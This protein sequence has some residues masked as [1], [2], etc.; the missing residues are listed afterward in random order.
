MKLRLFLA[1]LVLL[2]AAACRPSQSA[3]EVT[4]AVTTV[5]TM[6]PEYNNPL[7]AEQV[8]SEFLDHWQD[9][10]FAGMYALLSFA[11]QQATS[12][13]QFRTAYENAH[14]EMRL[15]SLSHQLL[16]EKRETPRIML[17]N[18]N[19]TFTSRIVGTF[20]DSNRD[21]RL[22]LDDTLQNWRVAWSADDIFRGMGSGGALR[23][24]AFAP[25]RANIYDV[26][27][28]ILADMEGAMIVVNLVLGRVP[29]LDMCVN[30]LSQ[31]TAQTPDDL[32]ARLAN[33]D[34]EQLAEIAVIER[35]VYDQWG[36]ALVNECA[37]TF[38][39]RA[40]RRYLYPELISHV[41]GYVGYPEE[42]EIEALEAA[43]FRQDS[44]IGRTG[45]EA[46]WDATLRGTPGGQ[47]SLVDGSGQRI[48]LLADVG[49]SPAKSVYLTIDIE[50][51]RAAMQ[52]IVDEY[53]TGRLPDSRGAVLIAIDVNTG[54]I[55]ALA[56]YPS[57]NL[58]AFTPYPYVGVQAAA[59][60]I[61][62]TEA[63]SRRPLLNRATQGSYP[64]GSVMK[65]VTAV[66][67][68]EEG[69]F[70]V[71]ERYA[72]SGVWSRDIPRYD[73]LRGGH[74]SVT[75]SEALTHSCNTCF[76][77]A[78]YRLNEKDPYLFSEYANMLGLGVPTGLTDLPEVTGLIG[79]PDN[80]PFYESTVPWSF[81]DAV[82]IAIGQGGVQ[83]TP[84]QMLEVYGVVA[85]GGTAYRPQLVDRVGLLDEFSYTMSP[86][87]MR[88]VSISI[89][90]L[91]SVRDGLCKVT[92][93]SYGTATHIF[94]DSPLLDIGVCGKTGTAT[95]AGADTFPHAWF[96]SYSPRE[97][98]QIATV[99]MVE[100]AG[101]GSAFAAPITR[102]FLEYY[103]FRN[104]PQ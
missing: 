98:P 18:Y 20:E 17:Y 76:Y 60:I 15:E 36:T 68:L 74:G 80:K 2:S 84:L 90:T 51:Q 58:N 13:E 35:G 43:G 63:D 9:S 61:R 40:T 3:Q 11:S 34:Q 72:S 59:Q 56:S 46:S 97:N 79:T 95:S 85:N 54:A 45:I 81:S 86:E 88:Q 77:E 96:M 78:G 55:L 62:E 37:A 91:Q 89:E 57:F 103:Y 5:P 52:A 47:L 1:L 38:D 99:V 92:T 8:V 33:Y 30:T 27:G 87:V 82:N 24:E 19:M 70:R 23:L 48:R 25:R 4:L 50:V 83:V 42:N 75:L 26:N 6:T 94:R 7:L 16:A 31:A 14:R 67:A 69:V 73:W 22:V 29:N 28:T 53:A 65:L 104:P 21:I 32:R 39:N 10:D 49:S 93:A 44:I 100:N 101:D 41:I 102:R 71:D 66:A 64:T 12:Y